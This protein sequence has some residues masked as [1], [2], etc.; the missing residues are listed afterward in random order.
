MTT[1]DCWAVGFSRKDPGSDLAVTLHWN[2]G[3]WSAS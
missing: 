2:G 3:K 1:T